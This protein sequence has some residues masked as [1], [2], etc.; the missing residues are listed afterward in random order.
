MVIAEQTMTSRCFRL[1]LDAVQLDSLF[2]F[3]CFE[4][5]FVSRMQSVQICPNLFFR[6]KSACLC[7]MLGHLCF[8]KKAARFVRFCT[9][10]NIPLAMFV[11]APA[12]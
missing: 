3:T 4:K 7:W 1:E 10:F 11:D 8:H 6:K 2:S 9:T 5:S 12:F